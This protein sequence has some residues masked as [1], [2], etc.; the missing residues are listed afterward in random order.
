MDDGTVSNQSYIYY[1]DPHVIAPSQ[2]SSLHCTSSLTDLDEEFASAVSCA[3]NT[4]PGLSFGLCLVGGVILGDGLPVTVSSSPR[5]GGDVCLVVK[6][7][8]APHLTSQ[9]TTSSLRVPEL[10]PAS[11]V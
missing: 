11:L 3:R 10:P 7:R 6:P 2:S 8:H 5:L 1:G 4:K 9:M